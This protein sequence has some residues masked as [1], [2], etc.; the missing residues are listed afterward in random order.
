MIK[1]EKFAVLEAFQFEIPPVGI[2]FFRQRPEGFAGIAEKLAFCEMLK[3]AQEGLSFLAEPKDH[4]CE[5]GLYVLGLAEAP[6]PYISGE[7]GAGLKIFQEPRAAARLYHHLPRIQ[8]GVVRYLA[9]APLATLPF[10]PDVLVLMAQPAQT[11]IILRALTYRSG[12][13]WTGTYTAAVGCA[14]I[15]VYPYV[16]GQW[17]YGMSGLGHGM[18]RRGL[19]PEGRLWISVPFDGLPSFLENLAEMPWTLPAYGPGGQEF[20]RCLLDELGL[21]TKEPPSGPS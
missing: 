6:E 3:R 4:A 19:F 13:L 5:A 17:N 8:P 7:F 11:E 15:M 14:W 18:K 1:K 21:I 9:F 16:K 10:D 2:K 12:G 20:V